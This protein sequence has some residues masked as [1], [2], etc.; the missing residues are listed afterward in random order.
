MVSAAVPPPVVKFV[1]DTVAVH[2]VF[3]LVTLVTF[4]APNWPL[5]DPPGAALPTLTGPAGTVI[6]RV[7]ERGDTALGSPAAA[8][9]YVGTAVSSMDTPSTVMPTRTTSR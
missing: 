9:A 5:M 1:D 6:D 7:P 2:V 8:P 3:A 4:T